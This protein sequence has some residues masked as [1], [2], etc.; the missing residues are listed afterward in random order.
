MSLFQLV[1][2]LLNSALLFTGFCLISLL[3]DSNRCEASTESPF[4][5]WAIASDP[6]TQETG[7]SELLTVRMA[8]KD[9]MLVERDLLLQ[10][11]REKFYQQL[12]SGAEK[13]DDISSTGKR[14]NADALIVLKTIQVKAKK[15]A[16]VGTNL[17]RISIYS[18]SHGVRIGVIQIDSKKGSDQLDEIVDEIRNIRSRFDS[19]VRFAIAIPPFAIENI[20]KTYDSL[21]KKYH[22]L[23]SNSL[24]SLP[25]VAILDFENARTIAVE[26]PDENLLRDRIIPLQVEVKYRVNETTAAN[27][28]ISFEVRKVSPT[29]TKELQSDELQLQKAS[30]WISTILPSLLLDFSDVSRITPSK[31][32]DLLKERADLLQKLGDFESSIACRESLLLLDSKNADQRLKAVNEY[33]YL[34]T[35]LCPVGQIQP[36]SFELRSNVLEHLESLISEKLVHQEE[37]FSQLSFWLMFPHGEYRSAYQIALF[38][39]KDIRALI[40]DDGL[41][42]QRIL[43]A[44]WALP[45]IKELSESEKAIHINQWSNLAWDTLSRNVNTNYPVVS[46]MRHVFSTIAKII[47]EDYSTA[48]GAG[49][50]VQNEPVDVVFQSNVDFVRGR[51]IKDKYTLKKEDLHKLYSDLSKSKHIHLQMY[52]DLGLL[53]LDKYELRK[54]TEQVIEKKRLGAPPTTQATRED[55]DKLVAICKSRIKAIQSRPSVALL[56]QNNPSSYFDGAERGYYNLERALIGPSTVGTPIDQTP[57]K[58]PTLGRLEFEPLPID[59]SLFDSQTFKFVPGGPKYDFLFGPRNIVRI[60]PDF[61]TKNIHKYP[62]PNPR[63]PI[64]DGANIYII[65]TDQEIPWEVRDDQGELIC[66]IDSKSH[67]PKS[68]LLDVFPVAPNRLLVIGRLENDTR[69]WCAMADF[70]RNSFNVKIIHE[71][72]RPFDKLR[73][74]IPNDESWDLDW[75]L[76]PQ[77]VGK[78][79]HKEHDYLIIAREAARPLL[80]DLATLKV[81]VSRLPS[82]TYSKPPIC[83]ENNLIFCMVTPWYFDLNTPDKQEMFRKPVL[84]LDPSKSSNQG[85]YP[86]GDNECLMLEHDGW[87]YLP[88]YDWYRFARSL[89]RHERLVPT[90]LPSEYAALKCCKSDVFGLIGYRPNGSSNSPMGPYPVIYRINVRDEALEK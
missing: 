16:G 36:K 87:I 5:V 15:A 22:D 8:S 56:K 47:P 41:F 76:R 65:A 77:S 39:R 19:G 52:G 29:E 17:L 24:S 33:R 35:L 51:I 13:P 23:L 61:T 42:L 90:H 55:V 64:W 12:I 21:S 37:V 2:Q 78:Y 79:R 88:G 86:P 84:P 72:R 11:E 31:Q 14:L 9:F 75:V 34:A 18:C 45:R 43:P 54:N 70:E 38:D 30:E 71:G 67:F 62:M 48:N 66:T 40:D 46:E 85:I 3:L 32:I 27:P 59:L 69:S 57:R 83:V 81:S 60:E 58:E 53:C 10:I 44:Y 89:D 50:L 1:K 63:T 74:R 25:G 20:D 26:F 80:I 4:R 82:L 73:P 6:S 68:E 49:A 28:T 7:F